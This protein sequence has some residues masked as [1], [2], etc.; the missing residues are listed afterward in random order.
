MTRLIAAAADRVLERVAPKATASACV[1]P[2]SWYTCIRGQR[3]YL[4]CHYTCSGDVSCTYVG[5][6]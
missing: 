3:D 1:P 2:E 5:T 4:H 6:C